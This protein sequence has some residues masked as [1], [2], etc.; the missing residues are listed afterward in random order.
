VSVALDRFQNSNMKTGF[1]FLKK[2]TKMAPDVKSVCIAMA[3][4]RE[5]INKS[6]KMYSELVMMLYCLGGK[7]KKFE[8]QEANVNKTLKQWGRALMY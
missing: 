3:L 7:I 2:F 6:H 8:D 5:H 1:Y 4:W